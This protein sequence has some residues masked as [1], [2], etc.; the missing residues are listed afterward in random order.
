MEIQTLS[1]SD[2]TD[3]LNS[4][5]LLIQ[6][7][8]FGTNYQIWAEDAHILYKYTIWKEGSEP[9]DGDTEQITSD[10][11]DFE[12]NYKPGGN[13]SLTQGQPIVSQIVKP[14]FGS[15]AWVFSH[16]FCDKTTWYADATRVVDEAVGTG[17]GIET[18][19]SLAN[20]Y[21]I[22]MSHGKLTNEDYT[23]PSAT[24]TGDSFIP[25]VKVNDVTLTETPFDGDDADYSINYTTGTITFVVPPANGHDIVVSYFYSPP[26]SGSIVYVRPDPGKVIHI[27][28]IDID[29]SADIEINDTLISCV[30]TY[31]PY[32]GAP[33]EKF[34]YPGSR[35]YYKRI[36]DYYAY[37]SGAF[38]AMPP[39]GGS[40]RGYTQSIYQLCFD[41]AVS[42]TLDSAVG[43]EMRIYLENHIPMG[44]ERGS[45]TIHAYSPN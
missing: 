23:F 41:Y 9:V 11:T 42:I 19:F 22:D 26:N 4:K 33:P 6:Y 40:P 2:F 5:S 29:L 15:R 28:S 3:I 38:P 45:V 12:E 36:W 39:M 10:R 20:E 44:G 14:S 35:A 34:E 8:D 21:V 1:W 30:Y 25:E 43:A 27:N 13:L 37:S 16:N 17:D 32:L 7:Y 24:Q 18:E 31:N